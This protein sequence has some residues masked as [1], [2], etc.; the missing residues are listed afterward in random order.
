[1]EQRYKFNFFVDKAPYNS[2]EPSL[3]NFYIEK[4]DEFF[5]GK[6]LHIHNNVITYYVYPISEIA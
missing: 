2:E 6:E 4:G 3:H 1:M 5:I